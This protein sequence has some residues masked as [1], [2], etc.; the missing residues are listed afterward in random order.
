MQNNK[1]LHNNKKKFWHNEKKINFERRLKTMLSKA[2]TPNPKNA[3]E[4][5]Q[6]QIPSKLSFRDY[7]TT[8][9]SR[10]RI[11]DGEYHAQIVGVKFV[12]HETD[13]TKDYL[14]LEIQL[15]FDSRVI[16][17]NRFISGYFLFEREIKEQLGL[18]DTTLPVPDLLEAIKFQPIKVWYKTQTSP[19]DGRT[20]QNLYFSKPVE[21]S[22][23][24]EAPK[25]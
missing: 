11:Q 7:I 5:E 3:T 1:I 24:T 23:D 8:G 19:K 17:E 12:P 2:K 4:E 22:T 6:I 9:V 20:Y 10:C 18:S 13:P 25:F 15:D 14:R 21:D 16:V